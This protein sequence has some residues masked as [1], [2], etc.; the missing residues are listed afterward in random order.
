MGQKH[1]VGKQQKTQVN[2]ENQNHR[3]R[4]TGRGEEERYPT[5]PKHHPDGGGKPHKEVVFSLPRE[6]EELLLLKM[7]EAVRGNLC[8]LPTGSQA[9]S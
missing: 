7:R 9:R 1:C 3:R 2:H 4:R 8:L 5:S 6:K